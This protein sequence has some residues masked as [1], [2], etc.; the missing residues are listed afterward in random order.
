MESLVS[1]EYIVPAVSAIISMSSAIIAL[2]G[3]F[4]T[5][6][7]NQFDKRLALDKELFEAA[8]SK[9]ESAFEML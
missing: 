8:V 4:F 2:V 7:K 1:E 6:R 9:L 3:L 5:Y